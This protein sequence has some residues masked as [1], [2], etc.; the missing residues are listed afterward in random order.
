MVAHFE[1]SALL[2]GLDVVIGHYVC[3]VLCKAVCS[4]ASAGSG[5]G[6]SSNSIRALCFR[7][8]VHLLASSLLNMLL[9]SPSLHMPDLHSHFVGQSGSLNP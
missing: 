5:K 2:C 3:T 4:I 6:F 8:R 7:R 9:L 1:Q